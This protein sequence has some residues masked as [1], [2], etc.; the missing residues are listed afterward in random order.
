MLKKLLAPIVLLAVIS[1]CAPK[2]IPVELKPAYTANEVLIRVHELQRLV[3]GLHDAVPSGI[4]KTR[5]DLVVSFT[6]STAE[7]L[8]DS[9][10]DWKEVTKA[11]WAT[12][13]S[14]MNNPE[15]GLL[16]VWNIIDAMIGA[17]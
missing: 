4:S 2:A 5:A 10:A 16:T 13:K 12:L 6:V 17:L 1:G 14:K 3:I 11:S 15:P 7:V 9:K 8:K